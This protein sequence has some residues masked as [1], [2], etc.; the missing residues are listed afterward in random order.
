MRKLAIAIVGL[1]APVALAGDPF[2]PF[3]GCVNTL[4]ECVDL[5]AETEPMSELLDHFDVGLLGLALDPA[6]RTLSSSQARIVHFEAVLRP[7]SREG[8]LERAFATEWSSEG[9]GTQDELR[10]AIAGFGSRYPTVFEQTAFLDRVALRTIQSAGDVETLLGKDEVEELTRSSFAELRL[11]ALYQIAIARPEFVARV[12]GLVRDLA[13]TPSLNSAALPPWPDVLPEDLLQPAAYESGSLGRFLRGLSPVARL[14]FLQT[15]DY[16][17]SAPDRL[18]FAQIY[19][20][21][22]DLLRIQ[23]GI[24]LGEGN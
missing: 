4:L 14:F 2:E 8:H 5:A 24:R 3:L 17:I 7:L 1:W 20:D 12:G 19:P 21:T 13:A 6:Q 15:H 9:I 23:N 22:A 10:D 11:L 18:L 16:L